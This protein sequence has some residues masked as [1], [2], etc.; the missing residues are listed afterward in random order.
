MK[1]KKAKTVTKYAVII[2]LALAISYIEARLPSFIAIPGIKLGLT[3]SVVLSVLYLFGEKK[4]FAVNFLRIVLVSLLFG[5]P[6][7]LIYSAAGGMISTTTMVF[8]KRVNK[9]SIV[10]V[11]ITGGITHNVGQIIVA[12]FLLNTVSVGWYL[13]LLFLS[14]LLSGAAVGILSA[15]LCSR[16]KKINGND[17]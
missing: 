9:F 14:G 16:L 17:L 13:P 11:S 6:V 8:M 3:N 15:I 5:S 7:G 4:A 1:N 12:M 10:T 2:T